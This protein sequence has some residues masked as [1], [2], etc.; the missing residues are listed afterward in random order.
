MPALQQDP[1]TSKGSVCGPVATSARTTS[2]ET[3]VKFTGGRSPC[4]YRLV[5]K[6]AVKS[7]DGGNV[8]TPLS[9]L[10]PRRVSPS[11]GKSVAY[12]RNKPP[13]C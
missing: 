7:F 3:L 1:T 8:Y 12:S 11:L 10:V 9:H 2:W 6:A 5:D 4:F 13:E